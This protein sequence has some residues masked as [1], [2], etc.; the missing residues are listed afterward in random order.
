MRLDDMRQTTTVT[1][2]SLMRASASRRTG[3]SRCVMLRRFARHLPI[4]ALLLSAVACNTGADAGDDIRGGGAPSAKLNA[5][6]KAGAYDAALRE[7]FNVDSE[8]VLLIDR[9]ILPRS[10][11]WES[12]DTLDAAVVRELRSA[13]AI[14]G[15]CVPVRKDTKHGPTCVSN[16]P[17]Y[18]VRVTDLFQVRGDT[19]RMFLAAD[20]FH[21]ATGIG[22]AQKF[23]FESGYEL[24]RKNG[25]WAVVREGRRIQK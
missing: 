13:G 15:E 1:A 20:R 3:A 6:Q 8:L 10:G 5:A 22:P 24:L 23:S 7:A 19:V 17:G 16:A 25:K 9:S 14:R 12:R 2:T 11:G 4:A 18:V 21:T